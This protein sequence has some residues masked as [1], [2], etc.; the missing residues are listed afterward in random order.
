MKLSLN[1]LREYL[2]HGLTADELSFRLTMAG[3]EVEH[4]EQTGNDTVFEIEV[5]PN[6]PDC[7]NMLGLAREVSAITEKDIHFPVI[8]E[9]EDGGSVNISIEA[10]ADCSRYIGTLIEGVS[11]K[12]F[13]LEKSLFLQALGLKPIANIVDL[14]NFVMFEQGQPMHAFDYD[15]IEGGQI[16]V[17]RAKKGEKIITLDDVERTLDENI[18]VIADV[19]K[20]VAIAGIMGGRDSGVVS[21]TKRVLLEAAQFDLGLI[22]RSSR[23]L[24][25]TSD[26]CYR[27]ERGISWRITESASNRMTDLVLQMAGGTVIARR[28]V[29]VSEP[30]RQRT[31]VTVTAGD[32]QKLL[33]CTLDMGRAEKILKRL[34][35]VVAAGQNSLSVVSPYF[36]NDIQ[37]K[38]DVIEEIGRVIGYDNLPMSLPHVSAVNIVVDH[39]KE[40][41]NGSVSDLM[42]AS[43]FNEVVLYSLIG[44][45]AL[46]KMG[47]QGPVIKLQNPMSAEQAVMRPTSLSQMLGVVAE[48]MNRGQR[49]LKLFEVGKKYLP[50][51]ESW[52]LSVLMAGRR[53]D[54]WRHSKKE[55]VDFFDLKGVVEEVCAKARVKGVSFVSKAGGFFDEGQS[56]KMSVDGKEA[57]VLGRVSQ[58]VLSRFDIKRAQVFFAEIELDVLNG[59]VAARERFLEL[60]EFP[61]A[62]RDISL[63]VKK[64]GV[65]FE[66]MRALCMENGHGLLQKIDFVEL[67]VG[68]KIEAGYRG[69][70]LSFSYQ[71]KDRTLTDKEVNALH[72]QL[73]QKLIET[74]GVVRR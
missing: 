21:T 25:L 49:D 62:V 3:L 7:L 58:E 18:L 60:N 28:D 4:V 42:V 10:V 52:T 43:G 44:T 57:G 74:F 12:A 40:N 27:F 5:T 33:G 23:K 73:T 30:K 19:K 20:P 17:R 29:I 14:S 36:R 47:Y 65:S 54:D 59:A 6:R 8:N 67:Y 55:M 24:G 11:V 56:S 9:Y 39:E 13:P 72:E 51:K 71:A 26:A 68:E 66:E 35:C 38:E 64:G 16:I 61:S 45:A 37:I 34:G 50:G 69:Y 2:D 1:W 70:V 41:F 31:E 46:E 15:K 48:N 22:R 63:A 53:D 32:I